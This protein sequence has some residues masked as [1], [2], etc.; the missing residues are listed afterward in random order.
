MKTSNK[1]LIALA[2]VVLAGL[3]S[4]N[5]VLKAE[6]EDI[7][8][9]PRPQEGFQFVQVAAFSHVNVNSLSPGIRFSIQQ[10]NHPSV[11]VY[12]EWASRIHTR[13]QNDTLF[14]ELPERINI[15]KTEENPAGETI[16]MYI[17]QPHL[18][19]ITFDNGL[20]S[21]ANWQTNLARI[22]LHNASRVN[23]YRNKI[24]DLHIFLRNRALFTV[25]D[26]NEIKKLHSI[27]S[28]SSELNVEGISV[29]SV[30]VE[31]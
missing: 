3:I 4:S 11:Q 2:V 24:N 6:Y 17:T 22:E 23:T 21:I 28:D 9:H 27:K 14:I 30:Q 25:E 5:I 13:V 7:K 18:T 1:L 10:D 15:P 8:A 31:K 26:D 29:G 16:G 12:S 20:G 19:S